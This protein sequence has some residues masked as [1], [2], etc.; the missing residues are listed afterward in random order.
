MPSARRDHRVDAEDER[1]QTAEEVSVGE[2]QLERVGAADGDEC[3]PLRDRQTHGG[4]PAGDGRRQPRA[5]TSRAAE[6]RREGEE[7][8]VEVV[9]LVVVVIVPDRACNA[10]RCHAPI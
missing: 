9:Q 2:R 8:A 5:V 4:R 3:T 10:S 1:T 6:R 7:G